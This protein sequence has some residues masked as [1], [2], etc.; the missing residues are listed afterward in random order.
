MIHAIVETG[1]CL[2]FPFIDLSARCR[3]LGNQGSHSRWSSPSYIVNARD[4]G[5]Y[6]VFHYNDVIMYAMASRITSITIVYSTVYL[7]ADQRKYQSS[8]SLAFV[9]EIH[10]WPTQLASSAEYVSIWWRHHGHTRRQ[11]SYES[12]HVYTDRLP[13]KFPELEPLECDFWPLHP[14][15]HDD[16]IK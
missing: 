14:C 6:Y 13:A 11:W 2:I 15:C 5:I 16:V 7:D 10:R 8:V 3:L 1:L 4:V 12:G 9:W